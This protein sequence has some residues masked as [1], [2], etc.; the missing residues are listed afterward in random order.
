MKNEDVP[1]SANSQPSSD[2]QAFADGSAQR[3]AVINRLWSELV[4]ERGDSLRPTL[5]SAPTGESGTDSV[6]EV[7]KRFSMGQID[8]VQLIDALVENIFQEVNVGANKK[9]TR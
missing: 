1:R 6:D 2:W 5:Y 4:E 8:Q 9:S 7:V 3:K